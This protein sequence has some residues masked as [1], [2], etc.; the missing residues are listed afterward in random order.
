MHAVT[1]SL[2]GPLL[3]EATAAFIQ[4]A[5]SVIAAARDVSNMPTLVRAFGCRVSGDRQRVTVF[6][7]RSQAL[8]LLDDVGVTAAIAVVFTLPSTHRAIQLKGRDARVVPLQAGDLDIV[9][10]R[11]DAF[12]ADLVSLGYAPTLVRALLAFEPDDLVA[13]GFTASAAFS[14]TPGARAGAPLRE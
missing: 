10:S 11:V 12:A 3:D 9:A 14:Q 13:V 4:G 6:V 2:Q 8:A 1:S 7:A 5:V